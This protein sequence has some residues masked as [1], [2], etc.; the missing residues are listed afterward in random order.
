[1]ANTVAS[2]DASAKGL[3][4]ENFD[5][6]RYDGAVLDPLEV[7]GLMHAFMPGAVRVLDVGCGTGNVTVIANQDRHNDI[8]GVEPDASR[9]AIARSRGLS[10]HTAMLDE[11]LQRELGL[12]DVVMS[13]DV[14]EHTVAP[15]EFLA[16]LRRSLKPGGLLLLSVPNVAHWSM[17]WNLVR[18]RFDYT[19]T[20]LM[21]ATHLRWFTV[22]SLS[23]LLVSAGFEILEMRQSVGPCPL[24]YRIR[25][26]FKFWPEKMCRQ[27]MA[28][29]A[30]VSPGFFGYQHVVKARLAG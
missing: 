3:T 18:G 1:M 20:G 28:L 24:P 30:K 16:L 19:P 17:R 12:F 27:S 13:S 9:A 26:Q 5:A 2:P 22:A 25:K 15:E 4:S 11:Q 29:G 7:T 8:V 21:D 23:R 14:L 10:V 6:A